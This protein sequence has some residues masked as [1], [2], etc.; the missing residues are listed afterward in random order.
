MTRTPPTTVKP[1]R[2]WRWRQNPLRRH[3]DV[4]EAWIVLVTWICALVGGS[5]AG[6]AAARSTDE[7]F[8]AR[9]AQVHTVSAVLTDEAPAN[10]PAGTGD[11]DGRVWAAVRWTGADGTVH[12]DRAK[13]VPG[14]PV[15]T[16]I[17]VWT[18]SSGRVVAAPVTGASATLQAALTGAL[19]APSVSAAVWTA[20]W[21]IR[22]RLIRRR[23][24]EWDQEWEQVGPE[25]GNLNGGR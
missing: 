5:L 19:V 18:D 6:A 25:W 14:A 21:G 2:L 1:V 17:T 7:A 12:S 10:P 20:G 3:S 24:A 15:G 23:M 8:A 4:V 22:T 9:E 13:V 16:R 11:D